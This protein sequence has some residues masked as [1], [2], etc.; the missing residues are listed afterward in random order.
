VGLVRVRATLIHLL[1]AQTFVGAWEAGHWAAKSRSNHVQHASTVS[2]MQAGRGVSGARWAGDPTGRLVS[3]GR[4]KPAGPGQARLQGGPARPPWRGWEGA[5]AL[6]A[7]RRQRWFPVQD[8]S[9]SV[10]PRVQNDAVFRRLS[11][12]RAWLPGRRDPCRCRRRCR[13]GP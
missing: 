1:G 5:P 9:H 7:H 3:A 11:Y 6:Q 8:R 2:P 12:R 4:G 13:S 10:E